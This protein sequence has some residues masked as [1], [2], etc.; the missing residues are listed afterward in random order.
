MKGILVI[1][2]C[3]QSKIW[4]KKAVGAVAAR[5]AYTGAPFKVNREYAERF[6]ERWVIL[7]A[8]YGFIPPDFMLSGPYNVTFKKKSTGPVSITVLEEQIKDMKLDGYETV[9]GLGGVEYRTAIE[10]EFGGR[11]NLVF[12]FSG[13]PLGKAMQATKRAIEVGR[14]YD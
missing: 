8:K 10:K 2:P 9:I 14:P 12:P 13:L 4:D 7:S 6:P 11:E 3:G 1:I 5:D